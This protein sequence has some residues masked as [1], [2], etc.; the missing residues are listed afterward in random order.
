MTG[1][2]KA[3]WKS[4]A[5]ILSDGVA[6]PLFYM[7]LGGPASSGYKSVNTMDSMVEIKNDKYLLS[8]K[9]AA[10]PRRSP[11]LYTG[12]TLR[13]GHDLRL[14]SAIKRSRI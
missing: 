6:A 12:E 4:V 8:W 3:A 10:K 1:V 9:A 11:E 5:K 14:L 2:T 7:A 13:L